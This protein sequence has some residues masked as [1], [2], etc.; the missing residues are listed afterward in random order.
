MN[1]PSD[2]SY[3]DVLG[4]PRTATQEQIRFSYRAL[5]ARYHPDKHQGNPLQ[6]LAAEKLARINEAYEVLS[7]PQRRTAYDASL[8]AARSRGWLWGF[9]GSK[10]RR[11]SLS[12]VVIAAVLALVLF[13]PLLRLI[14]ALARAVSGTPF[15][16]VLFAGLLTGGLWWW[17]KRRRRFR[18]PR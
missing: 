9:A 17:A 6:E 3:Y 2:E 16:L 12:T 14:G 4:V 7:D 15:G 13:R 1:G 18:P 11:L 8:D 5:A 10:R